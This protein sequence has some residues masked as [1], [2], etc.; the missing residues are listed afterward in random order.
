MSKVIS[1]INRK[2]GCGK[3]TSAINTA[4]ALRVMG[5]EVSVIETDTVRSLSAVRIRELAATGQGGGKFPELLQTEDSSVDEAIKALRKDMVDFIIVDGAANVSGDVIRNIAS[6]SD[7]VIIP[8]NL[9]DHEI[10]VTEWTL[11]DIQPIK[12]KKRKLQVALLANRIHFLTAHE[13]VTETLSFLNVPILDIYIP[14]FKQYSSLNTM[15]PT[16]C[17]REVA[18]CILKLFADKSHLAEQAKDTEETD[19]QQETRDFTENVPVF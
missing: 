14:N 16:E 15:T 6:N 4:T 3:T 13:T 2:G 5:F 11:N 17:Y 12:E 19:V 18:S 7:I 1:F 9:S 8:T 10:M